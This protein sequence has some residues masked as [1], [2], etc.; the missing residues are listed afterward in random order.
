MERFEGRAAMEFT[1]Q[2]ASATRVTAF[3]RT[4][5]GWMCAGLAVTAFVA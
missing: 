2:V 3:L 1:R 5:Y 4:V